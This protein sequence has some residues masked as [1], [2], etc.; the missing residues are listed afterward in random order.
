MT[1]AIPP[2]VHVQVRALASQL[3][4]APTWWEFDNILREIV[5]ARDKM[6]HPKSRFD[7][8]RFVEDES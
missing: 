3:A 1:P 6:K 5:L 8:E 7:S 4:S 2:A